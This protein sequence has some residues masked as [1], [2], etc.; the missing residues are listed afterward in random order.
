MFI[1]TN[2][3]ITVFIIL[4][5]DSASLT[6]NRIYKIILLGIGELMR[7]L[8]ELKWKKRFGY[9]NGIFK[10]KSSLTKHISCV[11][12]VCLHCYKQHVSTSGEE[13][14]RYKSRTF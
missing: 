11:F 3:R 5:T 2:S 10:R 12:I 7:K 4:E 9:L 8:Y 13:L 6:L 14:T 1:I